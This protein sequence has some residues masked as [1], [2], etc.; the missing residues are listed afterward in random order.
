MR[1]WLIGADDAGTET[2]RQLKK[3]PA[4]SVVVSAANERPRAVSERVIDRVDYV[5]SVTSVNINQLARRIRPDLILIDA[6]AARKAMGNVGG[7]FFTEAMNKE[8]ADAAECPC[9]LLSS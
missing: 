4:I 2:L 3:N 8:M 1:I 6:G 5:E 7:H 9:L